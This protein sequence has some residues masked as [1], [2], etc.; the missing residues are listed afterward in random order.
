MSAW[1]RGRVLCLCCFCLAALAPRAFGQAAPQ[2]VASIVF[3]I[4][5]PT[6]E[7]ALREFTGLREGLTF[8]SAAALAEFL[9]KTRRTLL[10][11][12]PFKDVEVL[13]EPGP[14]V[15]GKVE[16]EVTLVI[17]AGATL[18][19]LPD[20]SYDSNQGL[21]LGFQLHFTDAFGTL[22]DWFY[23][24]YVIENGDGAELGAAGWDI[25]VRAEDI[26]AAGLVW[27]VEFEL[28]NEA[29]DLWDRGTEL[30]SWKN[31]LLVA[32]LDTKIP[33][34]GL[35]YYELEP[36]FA[37]QFDTADMMGNGACPNDYSGPNYRQAIRLGEVEW[38]DDFRSGYEFRLEHFLQVEDGESG[39]ALD[40]EISATARC[41]L[42]WAFLDYY[43][44]LRAQADFG[45]Y[46]TDLGKYLRGIEDDS[47]PGKA[48]VFL[49]QTLGIDLGLPRRICDLQLHP[50]FDIGSELPPNRP[51]DARAD[52]RLGAGL[53]II[54]FTDLLP[55]LVFRCTYGLDL[56]SSDPFAD[57][58]I[59]FD[60]SMS[61]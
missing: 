34:G 12:E 21:L 42:P 15:D 56:G 46:P 38:K 3:R 39:P 29:L 48:A 60:T 50:F 37:A 9:D 13:D 20:V 49:N 1:N 55:G 6:S 35:W 58:E 30:A 51:W 61:Y 14:L 52:I 53:D 8:P 5:G 11:T 10:A 33:I 47:M 40:N 27:R 17:V 31:D 24:N 57:P 32:T 36:G 54:A 28:Q 25:H 44:R 7:K 26:F 16:H 59:L 41:Y 45:R 2:V 18:I 23:D 4:E 43:A 19:P 22:S